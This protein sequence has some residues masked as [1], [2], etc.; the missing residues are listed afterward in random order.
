MIGGQLIVPVTQVKPPFWVWNAALKQLYMSSYHLSPKFISHYLDAIT[1]YRVQHI[2]GYSSSLYA[3]AH[4]L[5]RAN[6]PKL[7]MKVAITNAEPLFSYQRETI[8]EA[9]N[10]PV[11]ETYGNAETVGAA[12][13]CEHG[14]LHLWPEVGWAEVFEHNER[15][16]DGVSGDFVCTGL[17][18]AD[19]PLIRYRIGDRVA[20]NI[21]NLSCACGRSLSTL[22]SLEGRIDDML[23]TADG[24]TIGRLDPVFKANLP[25]RGAQIVQE[26]LDRV[27]VRYVPSPEFTQEAGQSIIS[28][29]QDR[30]GRVDIV[31]EAVEE[32][33]REPGGKFRAVICKLPQHQ[34][35]FLANSRV[36]STV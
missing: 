29:L 5:I 20:L 24:R 4:E 25:I 23:Y 12:S 34:R 26:K 11:R 6:G 31:L 7:S 14:Q 9:F 10:C 18:N 22:A 16:A 36:P 28:R 13:E 15:V 32:L 2:W 17:I 3:L 33:S 27:R 1:R 21:G 35:R 8:K 30:M 19:M